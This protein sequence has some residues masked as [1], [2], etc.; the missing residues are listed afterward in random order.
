[1]SQYPLRLPDSLLEEARKAA[2]EDNTSLN[3]FI[4][5]AVS[6]RVSALK[7]MQMMKNRSQRADP[8]G[9]KELLAR[10]PNIPPKHEGDRIDQ[11]P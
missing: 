10:V 1:M 11:T 2:Q 4:S 5:I 3:Q 9:F 6:E 7:T 8:E